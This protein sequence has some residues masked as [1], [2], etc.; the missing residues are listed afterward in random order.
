MSTRTA[1]SPATLPSGIG[2]Y[3][4]LSTNVDTSEDVYMSPEVK[5][6]DTLVSNDDRYLTVVVRISGA[7]PAALRGENR[8]ERIDALK[9]HAAQTQAPLQEFAQR[10]SGVT[11]INS[12]WIANAVVLELDTDSVSLEQLARVSGIERLHANFDVEKHGTTPGKGT[13][14]GAGE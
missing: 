7:D 1:P 3:K 6:D 5:I 8:A 4:Q 14:S 9:Q 2:I 12:F 10:R 11:V 13:A